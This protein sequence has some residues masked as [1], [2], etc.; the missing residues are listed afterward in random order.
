MPASPPADAAAAVRGR[1]LF[2]DEKTACATCHAGGPLTNNK[3]VDVGTGEALQV[4]SLSRISMRAPYMHDG[5]AK[6]LRDRFTSPCGGGDKHGV[7]S[8]LSQ[9]QIDDLVA[10]LESL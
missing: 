1:A 10:F 9:A 6:T 3:T 2:N 8:H 5:C 7:T 4:P